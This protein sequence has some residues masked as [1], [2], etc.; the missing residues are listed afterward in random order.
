MAEFVIGLDSSTTSTKCVAWDKDGNSLAEGRA[1]LALS[2]PAPG[3]YEQNPHEWRDAMFDALSELGR[4]VDLREAKALGI[5]N[6]RETVGLFDEN[7]DVVRP[8]ILWLDE[9]SRICVDSFAAAVGADEIHRLTGKPKDIT[10]VVYSLAWMRDHE[11]DSYERTDK[12]ADVHAYLVHCLSGKW[13]TSWAS[14]DPFGCWDITGKEWSQPILAQLGLEDGRFPEAHRPGT[15]IAEVGDDAAQR[16]G[17]QQGLRIVAGG[18]DGQCAGVGMNIT[19]QG[20]AY[21]NMGTAVVSGSY[22]E[23][24]HWGKAWRTMTSIAGDGYIMECCLRSGTF[25]VNWLMDK[26]LEGGTG[27]FAQ[28]DDQASKLPP[29]S[30][31]LLLLPYWSGVMNPHWNLLATGCIVGLTESH[32][33]A[34]L[35]RAVLEGIA[36]EMDLSIKA[37]EKESGI[38]IA[39]LHAVGGG[40]KNDLWCQILADIT[41]KRVSRSTTVEA[42]ALGAGIAAAAGCGWHG[43][44]KAAA[45]AMSGTNEADFDPRPEAI[46][47]YKELRGIYKDLYASV[48]SLTDRLTM[49]RQ[50]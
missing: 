16:T 23:N 18:G 5:S 33:R 12:F 4:Q 1:A 34:H 41:G 39:S 44:M 35:Y 37:L 26:L 36:F 24:Y 29:G 9:R 27:L 6:Q 21:I 17:L 2:N 20:S 8:A 3:H 38:S 49:L 11:P 15:I 14:A 42:S 48:S 19:A 50:A 10:P 32:G 13:K 30:D 45:A 47:I 22:S 25:L 43:G 31:G 40:A 28:L 46:A 7:G